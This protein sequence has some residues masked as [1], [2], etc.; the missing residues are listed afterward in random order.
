MLCLGMHSNVM[1]R[2]MVQATPL[3][4]S[5]VVRV[6]IPPQREGKAGFTLIADVHEAGVGGGSS[7]TY[8]VH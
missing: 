1:L 6:D 5:T 2:F 3:C 4:S 8:T 7:P